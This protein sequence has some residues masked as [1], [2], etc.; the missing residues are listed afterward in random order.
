MNKTIAIAGLGYVGLSLATL[1]AQHNKVFA[2]DISPE[3]VNAVNNR[4]SPI[5]DEYIEKFLPNANLI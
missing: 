3:K 1:L 2:V 4:Q 5:R